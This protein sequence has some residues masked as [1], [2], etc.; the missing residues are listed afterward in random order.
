MATFN[1]QGQTVQGNQCNAEIINFGAAQDAAAFL[2]EL[3]KL[4]T[5]FD[6]GDKISSEINRIA[7][8]NG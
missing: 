5:Q 6:Q 4:K 7:I 2:S 1:Q 8:L 3:K